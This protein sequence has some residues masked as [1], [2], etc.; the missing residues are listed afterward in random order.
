MKYCCR[1]FYETVMSADNIDHDYTYCPTC[2]HKYSDCPIC[3]GHG[4]IFPDI[5][6]D[7]CT[8]MGII[9]CHPV[10]SEFKR[11]PEADEIILHFESEFKDH[12]K[13]Y[14]TEEIQKQDFEVLRDYIIFL[15]H[16]L[17]TI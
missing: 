15:I 13:P 6:C 5:G 14:D 1:D 2:G 11:W 16:E 4:L 3:D 10:I 8:G 9:S 17:E 7:I 12:F